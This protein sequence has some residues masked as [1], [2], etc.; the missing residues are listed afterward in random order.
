MKLLTRR[1]ILQ[2]FMGLP[3]LSLWPLLVTESKA[4]PAIGSRQEQRTSIGESFRGEQ[5]DYE[6]GFWLSKRAALG[7]LTF[8][9]LETQGRYV[10]TLQTETLG[11]LGWV[12]RYRVDVYRS[13]ME[14]IDGGKR[15]RS[16][17]FDEE[18]IIGGKLRG[19]RH[20]FDHVRRKWIVQRMKK[21]GTFDRTVRNIPEGK[22]YDDF[23]TAAY[24]FRYG[25]YGSIERSKTYVVPTF[26][27]KGA[28]S[29][30]IRVAPVEE[31]ER[32]RKSE[33]IK[34]GKDLYVK[35]L[36]DPDL[37]HSPEG[38]VEGWL[39]KELYP[40]EGAIKDVM[41]VGDLTGRLVNRIKT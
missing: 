11:I 31:E 21:D 30:E 16:L 7:K 13:T 29:Y 35:L 9:E 3:I 6:M 4:Q 32:R 12:A 26:P 41:L 19:R 24:N 20:A 37:T 38:V 36:L 5:L 22:I 40:V 25:V 23:I 1:Q 39:S 28:S 17:T 18:V 15:L 27:K 2:G 34:D 10:G 33:K 8:K 14:E